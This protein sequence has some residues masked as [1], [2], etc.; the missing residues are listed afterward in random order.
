[1]I[2]S[3]LLVGLVLVGQGSPERF[4]EHERRLTKDGTRID[5]PPKWIT[6]N[7]I[8]AGDEVY[9]AHQK[10]FDDALKA[11]G[12]VADGTWPARFRKAAND[13]LLDYQNPVK[14]FLASGAYVTAQEL[15]PGWLRSREDFAL[16][17][18]VKRGWE[19]LRNP[20]RNRTF[21]RMGFVLNGPDNFSDF[22][23]LAMK[24]AKTDPDDWDGARA[25]RNGDTAR[26]RA[27]KIL[28]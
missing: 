23:P 13:C 1:M 28:V 27:S 7:W 22:R 17:G 10:A 14:L 4:R 8:A 25:N 9:R 6:E 18:K 12:F 24:L 16:A 19:Y 26:P 11:K 20:P 5:P 21:V 15:Q 2:E 3:C